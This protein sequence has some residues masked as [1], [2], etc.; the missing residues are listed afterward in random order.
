M[1]ITILLILLLVASLSVL[2]V[3]IYRKLPQLKVLDPGSSKEAKVKELKQ[4]ILRQRFKRATEGSLASVRSTALSPFRIMQ[5]AIRGVA[6]KLTA[7]ERSYAERQ[8]AGRGKLAGEELRQLLD[9]IRA[10][11]SSERYEEAEKKLIEIISL[12]PKNSEAYEVLGRLYMLTKDYENAKE[13]LMYVLKLSPKDA[14][15]YASLGEIAELEG[16]KKKAFEV[17]QKAKDLSPNNPKYLDFF[18]EAA[19]E[20]EDFFAAEQGLSKLEQVNP[21]N[22]KILTFREMIDAGRNKK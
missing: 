10:L 19:I 3:V 7:I 11:V 1:I 9:E 18:I 6:S 20:N 13:T 22:Q 12:D 16:D 5:G 4:D 21:D 14:S 17:F 15:V 2:G 8:K